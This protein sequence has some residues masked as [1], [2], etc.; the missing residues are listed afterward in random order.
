M[1]VQ[2][3]DFCQHNINFLALGL[4]TAIF[5][6]MFNFFLL[7]S[8]PAKDGVIVMGVDRIPKLGN[9]ERTVSVEVISS[10]DQV[11]VSVDGTTVSAL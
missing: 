5:L 1:L 4:L 6:R 11:F 10:K 3:S 2:W 8:Q 9:K 7:F